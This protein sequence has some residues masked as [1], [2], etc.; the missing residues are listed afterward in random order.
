[1]TSTIAFREKWYVDDVRARG[2]QDAIAIDPLFAHFLGS[3]VSY[4]YHGAAREDECVLSR[5]QRA[6]IEAEQKGTSLGCLCGDLF[7]PMLGC[8]PVARLRCS[9]E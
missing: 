5:H 1:M 2:S 6:Y 4:V 7:G 3:T 8:A 9:E